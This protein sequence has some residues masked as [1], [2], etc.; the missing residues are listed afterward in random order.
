MAGRGQGEG[1][2][3]IPLPRRRTIQGRRLGSSSPQSLPRPA[4]NR[5]F[6]AVS[7]ACMWRET[8][9]SKGASVCCS[10]LLS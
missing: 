10:S 3:S 1:R 2:G 9:T 4:T 8:K 6:T 5:V 7:C